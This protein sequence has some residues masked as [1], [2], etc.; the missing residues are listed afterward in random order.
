MYHNTIW[1][2]PVIS[3]GAGAFAA[4]DLTCC[5]LEARDTALQHTLQPLTQ[6]CPQAVLKYMHMP[7]VNSTL[8]QW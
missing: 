6:H 2:W 7:F 3:D 5:T 1:M 8:A 4:G